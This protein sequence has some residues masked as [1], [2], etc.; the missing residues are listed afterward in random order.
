MR[1]IVIATIGLVSLVASAS[2]YQL[3]FSQSA[4]A[5]VPEVD[6]SILNLNDHPPLSLI[7]NKDVDI[8]TLKL[9]DAKAVVAMLEPS[10]QAK[11]TETTLMLFG[12]YEKT[13]GVKTATI[14]PD[15][16]VWK[17]VR[18][19]KGA[20]KFTDKAGTFLGDVTVTNIIDAETGG[21]INQNVAYK[22]GE[23][24]DWGRSDIPPHP[25]P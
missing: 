16:Q 12:D 17:L 18:A 22:K 20:D 6:V 10:A 3:Q 14:S 11:V 25:A 21:I 19:Y 7:P 2:L 1:R 13:I 4:K 24:K 9:P 23:F 5:Q 8:K 15:R